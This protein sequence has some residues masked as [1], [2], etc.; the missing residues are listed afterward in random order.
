M[1]H[2]FLFL[3]LKNK[4]KINHC[5]PQGSLATALNFDRQNSLDFQAVLPAF[6]IFFFSLQVNRGWGILHPKP[7]SRIHRQFYSVTNLLRKRGVDLSALYSFDTTFQWNNWYNFSIFFS[8]LHKY[9]ILG[10]LFC[11]PIH[12]SLGFYFNWHTLSRRFNRAI[13]RKISLLFVTQAPVIAYSQLNLNPNTLMVFLAVDY[14][15]QFISVLGQTGYLSAGLTS[16]FHEPWL[17]WYP[18][19]CDGASMLNQLNFLLYI[20][21][22]Q[23]KF[24]QLTCY[25]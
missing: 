21:V 9:N 19:F 5:L 2:S 1:L 24:L 17:L 6:Y 7:N 8:T 23:N 13:G 18:L 11:R 12:Y 15:F 16:I 4:Q 14:H 25:G 10:L 20:I 3:H 22:L